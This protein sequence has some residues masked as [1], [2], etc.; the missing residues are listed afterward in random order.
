MWLEE[1]RK[2]MVAIIVIPEAIAHAE[3]GLGKSSDLRNESRL[4]NLVLCAL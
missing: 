2:Q 3:Q 4:T 1:N